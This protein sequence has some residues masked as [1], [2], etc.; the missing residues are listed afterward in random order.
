MG[1]CLY[2]ARYLFEMEEV[3]RSRDPDQVNPNKVS[4]AQEL[5]ACEMEVED[6]S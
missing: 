2:V 3:R 5:V 4:S 1:G 6:C